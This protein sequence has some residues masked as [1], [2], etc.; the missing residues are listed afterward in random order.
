MV[1]KINNVQAVSWIKSFKSPS[2]SFVK[3]SI[4]KVDNW[5]SWKIVLDGSSHLSGRQKM[6]MLS[7]RF[8]RFMEILKNSGREGKIF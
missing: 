1:F 5:K 6:L 7:I 2:R 3:I 8:Y 4:R